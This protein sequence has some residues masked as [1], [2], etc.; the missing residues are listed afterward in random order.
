MRGINPVSRLTVSLWIRQEAA[1]LRNTP[2][3]NCT[4]RRARNLLA[5]L[6][7]LLRVNLAPLQSVFVIFRGRTAT[8]GVR[9]EGGFFWRAEK[10]CRGVI[11]SMLIRDI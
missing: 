1:R 6:L 7:F 3:C 2:T 10:I 8:S 4:I 11:K 5:R 9:S